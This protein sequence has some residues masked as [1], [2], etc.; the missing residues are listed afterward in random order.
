[1]SNFNEKPENALGAIKLQ[2][3]FSTKMQDFLNEQEPVDK[4][5]V[6][7]ETAPPASAAYGVGSIDVAAGNPL[8]PM[9]QPFPAMA[10]QPA[11]QT[12]PTTAMMPAAEGYDLET[13][14]P[15]VGLMPSRAET[16][17]QVS[18]AMNAIS[19]Q[20]G[21][22]ALPG[23]PPAPPVYSRQ[24]SPIRYSPPWCSTSPIGNAGASVPT[25]QPQGSAVG[26]QPIGFPS[27]SLGSIVAPS[28]QVAP[29]RSSYTVSPA[30]FPL[31][32]GH[33]PVEFAPP[34]YGMRPAWPPA[35]QP[36]GGQ[37]GLSRST[38][39]MS[40]MGYRMI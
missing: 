32:S 23:P 7:H 34:S 37:V 4:K 24:V 15:H 19:F 35:Q 36:G 20:S 2:S 10:Q 18:G 33:G 16:F 9:S 39:I 25:I 3:F 30:R 12:S 8:F 26:H 27:R 21:G 11:F 6:F 28:A 22:P 29:M 13:L 5:P 31:R 1:M 40:P 14:H 38:Y 17:R